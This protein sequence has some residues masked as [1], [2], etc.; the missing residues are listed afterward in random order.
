MK[1]SIPVVLVCTLVVL[2]TSLAAVPRVQA[3]SQAIQGGG[4][5]RLN[6][7]PVQLSAALGFSGT[8]G[9]GLGPPQGTWFLTGPFSLIIIYGPITGG[10]YSNTNFNLNGEVALSTATPCITSDIFIL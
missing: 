1:I 8:K 9:D 4:D 5:G 2:A 10:A 7:Q 6:C 3:S